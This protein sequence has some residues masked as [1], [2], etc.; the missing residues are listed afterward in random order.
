MTGSGKTE[1][2]L[3]L[4]KYVIKNNKTVLMLVPEISLTPMMVNAFKHKFGKQVAILHSKLSSGERYDEY[5]RII[6]EEV[7]IVVGARSAIFA[8]L[9][10]IGL[11]ILDEEHDSSYK[12]ETKPRYQTT[13]I[14]RIRG[15]YHNCPVILGS[16]TPSLESY[17]RGQKGVYDLY[18]LSKRINQFPLPKIELID[19]AVEIRNKNY[20]LFF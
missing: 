16:A 18:K 15:K 9:E 10:K 3:H 19:M 12:Q 11:I 20:S 6:N 4:S 7:K 5:R 13:Q 17:S 14:A 8:P 1:V 2:Y